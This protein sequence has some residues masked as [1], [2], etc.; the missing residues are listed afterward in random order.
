[1]SHKTR[2]S[3]KE[4]KKEPALTLKEKRTQR[5]TKKSAPDAVKPFLPG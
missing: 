1:M 5:R 3:N 4:V 2:K